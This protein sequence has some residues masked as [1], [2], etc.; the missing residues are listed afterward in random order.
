V[1]LKRQER[2]NVCCEEQKTELTRQM[3]QAVGSVEVH[4]KLVTQ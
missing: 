4:M 1:S 3:N 2:L